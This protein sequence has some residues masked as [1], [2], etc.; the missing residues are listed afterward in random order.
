MKIALRHT[1]LKVEKPE[2]LLACP[3]YLGRKDI[4]TGC[5]GCSSGD[6]NCG[7]GLTRP[8]R[9]GTKTH[10]AT[11][12]FRKRH[13][14]TNICAPC[15]AEFIQTGDYNHLGQECCNPCKN[16]NNNRYKSKTSWL[17]RIY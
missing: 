17:R 3:P 9:C 5:G 16:E 13:V 14:E 12:S 2:I 8:V 6:T 7:T 10:V 4:D 1:S 11:V 15:G